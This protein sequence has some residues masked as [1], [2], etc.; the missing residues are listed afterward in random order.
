MIFVIYYYIYIIII[1]IIHD[2]MTVMLYIQHRTWTDSAVMNVT[3]NKTSLPTPAPR[4]GDYLLYTPTP[5]TIKF[6]VSMI[7][8]IVGTLIFWKHIH[9]LRDLEISTTA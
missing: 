8:V 4:S 3:E 2:L 1:I 7:L 6:A 9:T 5:V